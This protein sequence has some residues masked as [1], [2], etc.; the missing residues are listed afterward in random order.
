[1]TINEKIF[2]EYDIR[3]IYGTDITEE[4]AYLFGRAFG[5]YIQLKKEKNVIVGYD[6]RVSSPSL[7]ESLKKGILSTGANVIE[8]GLVTTPMYYYAKKVNGIETG[9]MI[10]ASHNPKEYNGFKISFDRI[11]NAYGKMIQDFKEYLLKGEFINGNGT[12]S[13]IDIK[14]D[15]INLLRY[16]LDLGFRKVKV[17]VDCGNG[18]GSIIIKEILD[19][20]GITYYPLYCESDPEFPNHHPDPS[21]PENMIDLS[22]KVRELGYHMGI[23]F[24]GDAD[25]IGLVD[26][27]GKVIGADLIMAIFYR[28]LEDKISPKKAIYDVK[29]SNALVYDLRR[30]GY[31]TVMYRTGNSYM[32]AKIQQDNYTFGG[33]FSGHM[34]FNDRFPCFDDGIY[35]G[36]RLIEIISNTDKS[37]SMLLDGIIPFVS[38]KEIKVPVKDETKF[39]IVEKV[40]EYAVNKG[41]QL[42]TV[43]GARIEF[44]DG[45][46]LVRA[47]NTGPD[48]T[49]RFEARTEERMNDIKRE[50]ESVLETIK[51]QYESL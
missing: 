36:L 37:V 2:R 22:N 50:F 4:F 10:T 1:M 30:M 21:V 25:R 51:K 19:K 20:L 43:D 42:Y 49:I 12:E 35:A 46:A 18:T 27:N 24:D 33:E 40:K 23:A 9:I 5:S 16:S 48:L 45:F 39:Q 31:E 41:Y 26:E 3:G 44:P 13:Y 15:Y 17:V 47:S 8:L 38:T 32:N 11:G 6:N 7:F 29:C 14:E 34:W 28:N